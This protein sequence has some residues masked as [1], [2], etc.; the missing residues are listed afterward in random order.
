MRSLL[1]TLALIVL[2]LAAAAPVPAAQPPRPQAAFDLEGHRGTRGLRPENTLAA[3]GKALQIGVT[4]LELDTSVTRDGVVVVSHERRISPLECQGPGVGQLIRDLTFAEIEQLDCG[5]RHPPNPATDPF[6]ITQES[7]PGTHMP[8]LA[9]VF[10]LV[11]RY[12]AADVQFDIETKIDPTV[13]DTVDP[14]T[15]AQKVLGVIRQYGMTQRS[16]LQSFDWRTLVA[17]KQELPSLKTVA[18]AQAPTIFPGTP[19]TAGVSIAPDA[20]SAGSLAEAVK[21][22]GASVVSARFQDITD[23]LIAAA[24]RQGLQIVPW[25]V[26]DAPTMASL[27]D[28]GVD[29]LITD[30]P[31]IGRDVMAQKGMKLPARYASPFDIEG[32]RGARAYRPENT[33]PAFAY[34]LDHQVT[35]L[36][37]DTGVTKDGVLVVVHD[38]AVNGVHCHDT[39]PASP[40]DPMFPYA[41]DLIKDLTL[42]QIKTLDCGFTDPGF[43]QQLRVAAAMPTLQEVF[44]FVEQNAGYPVRFNIETKISPLVADTVPYEIFTQKLVDAIRANGLESRVMIQSFDW[45]TIMLAKKLDPKIETVALVWQFGA[46]DCQSLAD[47][48]SLEARVGDPSLKSPWTGGLDWWS[49]L[50]LGQ[51]VARAGADVVSSNWQVHDPN[52]GHVASSDWYLKEDP[53]MYHGPSI[54]VLQR[55]YHQ[56]VVPYTIDDESTMQR[57]IGLGV[58]GIISDDVDLLLRVAK[59]N[60]LA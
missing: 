39:A 50:D 2:A 4:T 21:S 14:A 9:Q 27:I 37:L 19:W 51:L 6:V 13:S 58:D 41:G 35:T 49:Y 30:Y 40:G 36:E 28:R 3:F 5:T 25:T 38:R 42:A 10:E 47:E 8:S 11:D 53:A 15:F 12:G 56:R 16:L 17:A 55:H 23:P 24:H 45:R 52:L 48:C 60:G 43:P 1:S 26:N 33:L 29:G 20:W 44:D 34:A 46:P 54:A 59:R 18:L 7:V 22:I 32:H 57:V 31:N